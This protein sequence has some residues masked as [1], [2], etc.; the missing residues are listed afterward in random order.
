VDIIT[1]YHVLN[2][3]EYKIKAYTRHKLHQEYNNTSIHSI[4]HTEEQDPTTDE[5]KRKRRTTSTLLARISQPGTH[6]MI[7]EEEAEVLQ[8]EQADIALMSYHRFTCTC[9]YCC[10]NL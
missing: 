4:R 1:T 7:D 2:G 5:I 10:S 6:P 8:I 9:T 3:R